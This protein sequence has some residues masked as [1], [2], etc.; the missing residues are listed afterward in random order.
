MKYYITFLLAIIATQCFAQYP[1]VENRMLSD[2]MT[3]FIYFFTKDPVPFSDPRSLID[4]ERRSAACD[5]YH[6]ESENMINRNMINRQQ[7][8]Q[9]QQQNQI[10]PNINA[11]PYYRRP[12]GFMTPYP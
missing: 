2:S 7:P 11:Y 5:R 9:M 10:Q 3:S 6:Q 12:T 8:Q 1:N 4:T